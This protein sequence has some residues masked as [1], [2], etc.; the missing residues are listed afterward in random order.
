MTIS[1]TGLDLSKLKWIKVISDRSGWAYT[2]NRIEK[3]PQS[4]DC[5]GVT[6]FPLGFRTAKANQLELGEQIALI[7]RG[8]LTH[9]IEI[10]D[11]QPYQEGGWHHRVC[12]I[13]WWEPENDNWQALRPQKELLG[14]DPALQDGEIHTIENLKR[15][16]ERWKNNKR[17][18]GFRAFLKASL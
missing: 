5:N 14:F 1:L 10:M 11:K 6:V 12:R 15:F 18:E 7:Q 2:R 13:L 16:D 3:M 9:I 4:F 17:M 8:K